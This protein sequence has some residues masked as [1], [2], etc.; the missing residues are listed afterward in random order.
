MTANSFLEYF[1]VLFG[2]VMNN[3]MWSILSNTGLFALPLVVRVLGVW[4]KVREEGLTRGTKGSLPFRES[5][6]HCMCL[7]L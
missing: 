5:N 3:A 7:I 6:M 2:W 4:L 1:L